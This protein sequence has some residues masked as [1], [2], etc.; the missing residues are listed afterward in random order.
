LK[1]STGGRAP[2][3]RGR[4]PPAEER[5]D[6]QHQPAGEVEY[7]EHE[8]SGGKFAGEDGA[9]ANPSAK[10]RHIPSKQAVHHV[11]HPLSLG[12]FGMSLQGHGKL[13]QCKAETLKAK[14]RRELG[15]ERAQQVGEKHGCYL[16]DEPLFKGRLPRSRPKTS[17]EVSPDAHRSTHPM[18]RGP[19]PTSHIAGALISECEEGKTSRKERT[20]DPWWRSSSSP[21]IL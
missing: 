15:G 20:I 12:T 16:R 5:Q 4:A 7:K 1:I 3:P 6:W 14:G 19:S 8:L 9:D 21:P 17:R 11:E 18:T 2:P 13:R 10:C